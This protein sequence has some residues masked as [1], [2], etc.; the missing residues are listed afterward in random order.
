MRVILNIIAVIES[1]YS[2]DSFVIAVTSLDLCLPQAGL[3][4]VKKFLYMFNPIFGLFC[5]NANGNML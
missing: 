4:S 5:C 2:R 1:D 3:D